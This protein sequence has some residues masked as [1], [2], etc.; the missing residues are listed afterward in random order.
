MLAQPP[1]ANFT[2]TFD[3]A[4]E[5]AADGDVLMSTDKGIVRADSSYSTRIFGVLQENPVAV[6]RSSNLGAQPVAR[7]GVGMVNLTTVNGSI[8]KG[9]FLTSS[10]IAGKAQKATQSGYVL[11]SALA[12]FNEGSGE[13]ITVDGRT[14]YSGKVEVALRIEYAEINSSRNFARLLDAFNEALFKNLQNPEEF[15]QIIRYI[16]AGLVILLSF[17]LGYLSFTRSSLKSIEAIG[18][19]P[20]ARGSIMMSLALHIG[21]TIATIA[22]GVGLA[23][24]LVRL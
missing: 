1:Q 16:L 9:D 20:L 4:D 13:K 14:V 7:T 10:D 17:V 18:R 11:G 23:I 12:D 21:L 15:T 6:Y 19:N 5:K 2:N 24:L 3:I 8:Q 22:I